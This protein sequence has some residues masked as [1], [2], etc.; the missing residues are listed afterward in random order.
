M[1]D[2]TL[3]ANYKT[4][5]KQIG[6]NAEATQTL[7]TE[8]K[9]VQGKIESKVWQSDITEAVTPLGSSITELSDK[10]TSQQQTIE[11]ITTEIG[12]VQTS[13]ESKADG[14]TVQALTGRVNKVERYRDRSQTWPF[15]MP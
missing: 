8:F 2:T 11:G 3:E 9:E 13:L 10:Y 4:M 7:Q 12:D 5:T 6:D 1:D 14:S 15:F